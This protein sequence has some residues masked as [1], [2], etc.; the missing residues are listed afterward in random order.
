MT[1]A[2][3]TAGGGGGGGGGGGDKD[4]MLKGRSLSSVPHVPVAGS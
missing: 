2:G 4:P 1:G 3:W